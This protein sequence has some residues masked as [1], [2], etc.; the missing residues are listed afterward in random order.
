MLI[1]T[2]DGK[3]LDVIKDGADDRLDDIKTKKALRTAKNLVED[4]NKKESTVE[5]EKSR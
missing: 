3:I 1:K 2:G 5:A 4:G